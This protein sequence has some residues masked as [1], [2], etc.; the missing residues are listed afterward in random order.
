MFEAIGAVRSRRC[1]S[2]RPTR[3]CRMPD[4]ERVRDA[5][6][7]C[8]FVVSGRARE[9]HRK[10]ARMCCCRPPPGAR[11]TAPS[12]IP[13]GASRGSGHSCR[14]RRGAAGLVER[15]R[16]RAPHGV[17]RG[18]RLS[19]RRPRFCA[20]TRAL[21]AFEND[22]DAR[23]R[24]RRA[25]DVSGEADYDALRRSS[26]R[27]QR[28]RKRAETRFFADGR[29]FTPTAKRASSRPSRRAARGRP[30]TSRCSSTPA[31]SATSGTR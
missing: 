27:D 23:F 18:V 15:G 21:S 31:A 24:Y 17:W 14:A 30:A 2:W 25:G 12:P 16:S 20:S 8:P 26:G 28:R 10:A 3:R 22:G 5:M 4:A 6:A 7:D 13:S 19:R 1:G 11:R 9:R 29:F